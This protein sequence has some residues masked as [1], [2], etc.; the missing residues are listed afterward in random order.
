MNDR[1]LKSFLVRTVL[2]LLVVL[3][4]WP[5]SLSVARVVPTIDMEGDPGDGNESGSSGGGYVDE[6]TKHSGNFTELD[7][8]IPQIEIH[9]V[10]IDT[11]QVIIFVTT[12][13]ERSE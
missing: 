2:C 9:F 4:I 5:A 10:W 11:R 12:E 8:E 1:L 6:D 13:S 3:A 7:L